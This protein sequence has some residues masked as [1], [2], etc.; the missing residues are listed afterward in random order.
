MQP[1]LLLILAVALAAPALGQNALNDS[2][3]DTCYD[4]SSATGGTEPASYPRQDC[5]FG[6][7]AA[8]AVAALVKTGAGTKGFDFTKIGNNGAT[9]L[10]NTPL[11]TS[12]TSWACTFDNTT[13]LMWEV[14][15]AGATDLR[16][17]NSTYSWYST[18]TLSN[19]GYAGTPKNGVCQGGIDCDTMSYVKAVNTAV[20]CGHAD[21][22][23]PTVEELLSL[24]DFSQPY[25]SATAIDT[26]YFP[27]MVDNV[28]W[29]GTNCAA[30][31]GSAAYVVFRGAYTVY[32]SKSMDFRALLVRS[33]Q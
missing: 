25:G 19:G 6:R 31:N 17:M 10:A 26:V 32:N 18:D 14:K 28:Y 24:A 7:D 22:R 33:G 5:R 3:L 4:Y 1:V 29:T 16:N 27:N 12:P 9:L 30:N 15:T 13:G 21:W 2:G 8:N 11:G 23:L 20:L